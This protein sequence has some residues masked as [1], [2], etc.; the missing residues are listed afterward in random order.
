MSDNKNKKEH[1][2]NFVS[3]HEPY[4]IKYWTKELSVSEDILKE[5]VSKV[6]NSVKAVKKF[7]IDDEWLD[8]G[9]F[10]DCED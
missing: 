9:W 1:D 10:G 3:L 8:E 5:A 7:L 6:G 2:A 4:E